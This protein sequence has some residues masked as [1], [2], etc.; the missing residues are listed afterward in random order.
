M[1]K[2]FDTSPKIKTPPSSKWLEPYRI[3]I[4]DVDLDAVLYQCNVPGE[5]SIPT[6]LH[7]GGMVTW[8]FRKDLFGENKYDC[9]FAWLKKGTYELK[10]MAFNVFDEE[11]VKMCGWNLFELNRCYWLVTQ[12]GAYFS[13]RNETFLFVSD[14]NWRYM[15]EWK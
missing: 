15:Y 4:T 9:S 1:V 8:K 6:I 10:T 5:P 14:D 7:H 3:Y 2:S 12:S 13:K 11:V